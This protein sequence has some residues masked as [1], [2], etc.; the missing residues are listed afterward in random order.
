MSWQVNYALE[1]IR[2]SH[3]MESAQQISDDAIKIII[4][5]RSEAI[6][7]ISE[8]QLINTEAAAQYHA[9]YP[10]IDFLCGY[11]KECAWEGKAI[12]YLESKSVG[13]GSAGT[14]GSA[15][16]AGN[17]KTAAH[18]HYF[19][20]YRLIRQIKSVSNLSREFDRVFTMTLANGRSVRVGMITEYEPT[21]D[22]I[23][24]FWDRFGPINIAWNINPNGDP[25]SNAIE[26]GR[27]L[28]CEV[29]KWE[30]LRKILQSR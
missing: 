19:F 16:H 4:P 22:A 25:T 2:K 12:E 1:N 20:S 14:L 30:E 21:A 8:K 15:I 28:G 3:G 5:N 23:R 7:V 18:K 29:V 24:T 13:W 27:S 10:A 6:A 9:N 17:I 26:A 11:R